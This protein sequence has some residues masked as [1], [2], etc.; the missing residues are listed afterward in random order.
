MK[1]LQNMVSALSVQTKLFII[2]VAILALHTYFN[3]LPALL[4][5][6]PL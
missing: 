2:G 3:G 4:A 1:T 6:M 5:D